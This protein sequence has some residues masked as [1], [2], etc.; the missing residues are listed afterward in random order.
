[1]FESVDKP[2]CIDDVKT[3]EVRQFGYVHLCDEITKIFNA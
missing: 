2:R 3:N 1:M